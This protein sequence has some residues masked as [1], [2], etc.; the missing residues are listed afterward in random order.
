MGRLKKDNNPDRTVDLS[1]SLVAE[2]GGTLGLFL[3]LSFITI[4]DNLSLLGKVYKK[5]FERY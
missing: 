2:F 4:W 1:A 3:G 5:V